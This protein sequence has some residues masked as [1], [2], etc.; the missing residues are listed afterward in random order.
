MMDTEVLLV[1]CP[2]YKL[3]DLPDHVE[4][5]FLAWFRPPDQNRDMHTQRFA[6]RLN[7]RSKNTWEI[8]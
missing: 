4:L 3:K 8:V 1:D 6:N 5:P 2:L 7:H